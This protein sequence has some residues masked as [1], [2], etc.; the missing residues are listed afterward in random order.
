MT[1]KLPFLTVTLLLTILSVKLVGQDPGSHAFAREWKAEVVDLPGSGF[2]EMVQDSFGF[3]W[4]GTGDGLLRYDGVQF[5][6]FLHEPENSNSLSADDISELYLE[7][8]RYLWIGNYSKSGLDRMDLYTGMVTHFL[9]STTIWEIIADTDGNIWAGSLV[10]VYRIDQASGTKKYF[11]TPMNASVFDHVQ[12]IVQDRDG[13]IWIGGAAHEERL[14]L[15][16]FVPALD[17]LKLHEFKHERLNSTIGIV[18][19][20]LEDSHGIFWVGTSHGKLYQLDRKSHKLS[21]IDLIYS[22]DLEVRRG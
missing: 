21:S 11:P 19:A 4:I 3:I 20:L 9:D 16:Q 12:T 8:N 17:T 18:T 22:V 15:Y 6:T 13:V 5:E 2:E 7:N 1:I 14:E 10:G